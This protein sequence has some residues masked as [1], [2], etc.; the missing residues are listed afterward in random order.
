M[1]AIAKVTCSHNPLL[2]FSSWTQQ[3]CLGQWHDAKHVGADT[4]LSSVRNF[5]P[6]KTH[7][8]KGD[9]DF[10]QRIQ[11]CASHL[12]WIVKGQ[13]TEWCPQVFQGDDIWAVMQSQ[14]FMLNHLPREH[15]KMRKLYDEQVPLHLSKAHPT[16]QRDL[17]NWNLESTSFVTKVIPCAVLSPVSPSHKDGRKDM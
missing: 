6:I 13:L 4:T 14:L 15:F 16:P 9:S 11:L 2:T 10:I 7:D 12:G 5:Y 17:S 1:F 3:A 8:F